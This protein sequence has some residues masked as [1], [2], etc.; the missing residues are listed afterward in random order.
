[1]QIETSITL[2]AVR[3]NSTGRFVTDLTNPSHKFWEKKK[4]C[5][6]ALERY[7]REYRADMPFIFKHNPDNLELVELVFRESCAENPPK[8][9]T[10]SHSTKGKRKYY[11]KCGVCGERQ[12]QSEMIR[13]DHS[14]NGWVCFDCHNAEH[15]EYEDFGEV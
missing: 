14:S 11:R 3:D 6:Q 12:E 4:C 2:Y 1:M 7:K 10:T 9:A 5:E 13:T 8:R 15:P